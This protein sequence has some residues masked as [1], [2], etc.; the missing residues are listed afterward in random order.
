MLC[1]T[2]L[3]RALNICRLNFRKNGGNH[4]LKMI[5]QEMCQSQYQFNYKIIKCCVYIITITVVSSTLFN[6]FMQ[7]FYALQVGVMIPFS[8][9]ITALRLVFIDVIVGM[10]AA[11][12][13]VFSERV[14]SPTVLA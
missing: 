14:K 1:Y 5:C 10:S 13:T 8:V 7:L 2:K 9:V 6:T 4:R 12:L 11:T 3:Y